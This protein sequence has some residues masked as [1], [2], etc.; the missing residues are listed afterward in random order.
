MRADRDL[1][2]LDEPSSG[3]DAEAEQAIHQQLI[4]LGAAGPVC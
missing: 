4:G 3:L 1:L 2:I